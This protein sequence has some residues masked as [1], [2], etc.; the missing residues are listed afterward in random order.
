[1]SMVVVVDWNSIP[2]TFVDKSDPFYAASMT[3]LAES[4]PP[5]VL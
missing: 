2:W 4:D 3:H 1:M 5:P